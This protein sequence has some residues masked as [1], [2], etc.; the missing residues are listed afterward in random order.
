[1]CPLGVFGTVAVRSAFGPRTA[2]PSKARKVQTQK[3]IS[4][5]IAAA[6]PTPETFVK[7]RPILGWRLDARTMADLPAFIRDRMGSV[8]ATGYDASYIAKNRGSIVALQMTGDGPD[9]YIVG[10][11][12]Y[13]NDYVEVPL[14]QVS[15]KNETLVERLAS[16]PELQRRFSAGDPNLVGAV[17]TE[18]VEMIAMSD[19]G[20][21]VDQE[22]TIDSPWGRQ[23]KPAGREAFLVHDSD[24]DQHY[25]IN[26]DEDGLPIGYVRAG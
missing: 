11:S 15:A 7:D 4:N 13:R 8:D 18:P 22:V 2:Q 20:Y 25:M 26:A 24:K 17:K 21:D 23:T 1:M 12:A 10:K 19:V 9:F 5:R 14:S 3:D 6:D 16:I